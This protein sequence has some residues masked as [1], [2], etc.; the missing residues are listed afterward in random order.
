MTINNRCIICNQPVSD[1]ET[2]YE[3]LNTELYNSLIKV[4]LI[5]K[6]ISKFSTKY[7]TECEKLKSL[8]PQTESLDKELVNP[9]REKQEEVIVKFFAKKG[10]TF[11]E[12]CC[13]CDVCYSEIKK[14]QKVYIFS[15][16]EQKTIDEKFKP[17][18][19]QVEQIAESFSEEDNRELDNEHEQI[20]NSFFVDLLSKLNKNIERERER[21]REQNWQGYRL[22]TLN[23][24]R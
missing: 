19:I 1:R 20:E 6:I 17:L 10:K 11:S 9:K 4:E 8:I 7:P 22:E 3:I 16:E 23:Y 14:Q 15:E 24:W 13:F 5:K 12:K 18:N 2:R 21:E